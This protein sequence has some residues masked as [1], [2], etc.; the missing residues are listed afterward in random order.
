MCVFR[1]RLAVLCFIARRRRRRR[2]CIFELFVDDARGAR[3]LLARVVVMM[4]VSFEVGLG[5]ASIF[6]SFF[7]VR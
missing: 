2:T 1:F 5:V 7:I 4:M 3:L 6:T